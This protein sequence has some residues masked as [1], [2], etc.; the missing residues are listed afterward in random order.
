[1]PTTSRT[2]DIVTI[3]LSEKI[4]GFNI[5]NKPDMV[6]WVYFKN[7]SGDMLKVNLFEGARIIEYDNQKTIKIRMTNGKISIIPTGSTSDIKIS[8]YGTFI[9]TY[10]IR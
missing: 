8:W 2:D 9:I 1:M 10:L 5:E 4:E 7:S 6:F 3:V